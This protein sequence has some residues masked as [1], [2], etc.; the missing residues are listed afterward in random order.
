[1]VPDTIPPSLGLTYYGNGNVYTA[2]DSQN[3]S[4]TYGYDNVNRLQTASGNGQS[5]TYNVNP[6]P[7]G[8]M[9]CT[10]TGNLPCTPLG[11]SFNAANNQITTTGY[12]YD[13]AGNLLSDNTHGYVYDLENRITC[14]QGTDG[15]CTSASPMLYLYGPDGQRAG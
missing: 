9:T 13:Q 14:V 10:N 7:W 8:N 12:S 2:N 5:F 3:G 1:M 4:W 15:T 11:L 6:N